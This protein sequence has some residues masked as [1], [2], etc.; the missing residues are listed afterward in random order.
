MTNSEAATIEA[1]AGCCARIEAMCTAIDE[2]GWHRPTALPG[3]DI[4]DVVAHLGSLDAMLLGRY[5]EH[6][7]PPAAEHVRNPL[8][9]L[10]ELS[11]IH[12]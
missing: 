12:I 4:Q 3:W 1:I 9:A 7:E 6:H 8:G 2:A 10:N 11:L 5:E